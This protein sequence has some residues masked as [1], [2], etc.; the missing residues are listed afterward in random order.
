MPLLR[1]LRPVPRRFPRSQ[2]WGVQHPR[3]SLGYHTG[4]DFA[5][6]VGTRVRSPRTGTV[7]A[8]AYSGD[9]YGNYVLVR[10]WTGRKAFLMAHLSKRSVREGQRVVRGQTLGYSGNTGM[11]TAAHL[12]AEQRHAPFGFRDNEKPDWER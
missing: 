5:V 6:P 4:T 9:D 1:P 10:D 7:I 12:H 2:R 8:S 3:Y 11:T